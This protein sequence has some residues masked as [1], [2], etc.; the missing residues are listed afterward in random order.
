MQM[1]L[2][3]IGGL[4][5]RMDGFGSNK[6]I[7]SVVHTRNPNIVRKYGIFNWFSKFWANTF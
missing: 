6:K 3:M 4:G 2:I 5:G 1:W 7:M